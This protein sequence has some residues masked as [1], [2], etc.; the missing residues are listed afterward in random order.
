MPPE[1]AQ[2]T[3]ATID[4]LS[5]FLLP[6]TVVLTIEWLVRLFRNDQ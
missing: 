1:L 2:L 5:W 6:F 4:L 3:Q